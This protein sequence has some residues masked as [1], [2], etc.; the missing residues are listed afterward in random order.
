M[1]PS[2]TSTADT[3]QQRHGATRPAV[4]TAAPLPLQDR[5][6]RER[7]LDTDMFDEAH[8]VRGYD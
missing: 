7:D 5:V 2:D 4:S 3:P 8:V 1:D 6:E